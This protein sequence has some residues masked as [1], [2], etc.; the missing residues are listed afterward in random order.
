MK[1]KSSTFAPKN[2]TEEPTALATD[3]GK[4]IP[5]LEGEVAERFLSIMRENDEKAK[6]AA[7]R[8][9]T[10]EDAE[11]ELAYERM[12]LRMAE[13]ELKGRKNRIKKLEQIINSTD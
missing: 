7:K 11:K 9:L 13:E 6:E 12:F 4:V 3:V 5:I 8:P 2:D 1:E 10:K